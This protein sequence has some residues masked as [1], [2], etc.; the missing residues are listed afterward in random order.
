MKK[1]TGTQR[2]IAVGWVCW[3]LSFGAQ[4]QAVTNKTENVAPE[5]VVSATRSARELNSVPNT[6]YYLNATEEVVH[7]AVRTTPDMLA[8]IPSAFVQ[9]TSYGQGSPYLRG[10]TGFRTLCL[11]DGIRLNNSV[12]RD[13]P[14]QYWNTVDPLSIRAYELVMGPGSV[15]YGSDAVGGTLNALPVQPPDYAGAPTWERRLYYR[16]ATVD[17][18]N[19]GRLQLGGRLDEHLGFVGGVSLKDFGDVRGGKAVGLQEHTGYE[20]LDWDLRADYHFTKDATLTL[21]HQ[22]VRQEDTWRTHRTVY[23]ITWDG[24]KRGDDKSLS[25]DQHRDL[26]YLKF[27]SKDLSGPID[28]LEATVSRQVQSEDIYRIKKDDKGEQQGFD[29]TTWGATLQLQSDTQIGEW[30]YG[31]EY[32]RDSV[33]SYG[34]KYKA[35]GQLDSVEVQGPVADDAAYH[36]LGAFVEDTLKLF[37]GQLDVV[38]GVRYT[39]A[40]VEANRV[41]EP[42]TGKA[43]STEGNWNAAVGSLRLLHP[44]TEDRKHVVFVGVSQGFRA[45]NLSDLTR[46]DIARSTELETPVSDLDPERFV[47]YEIGIKSRAERLTTQ[48]S[49]YYTT[50]EDMIVRAPTG[51]KIDG[52]DEVTKKNSGHG[53]VQ[54]VEL[55][56]TLKLGREWSTWV[57]AAWMEGQVDAYPN[58]TTQEERG[59]LGRLMPPTAEIG[60]RW[61]QESGRYWGELVGD[62][63]A[64]ADKLSAD[65]ARDTQR[66]PPGGTPGYA[67]FHARVGTTVVENLDLT[68]ALENIFDKDYRIHGSGVNEPGRNLVVTAAYSF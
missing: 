63:A 51:R 68:L 56:E 28:G 20:E 11:V 22:T 21:A 65:D 23:G 29:V 38:P 27:Q 17:R 54:G 10:F 57:S 25:Y 52:L 55:T 31:A 24:L 46:L 58:S 26:T 34:R 59:Y 5:I 36:T 14:N 12:F 44:L 18:S 32:Y 47:S 64:K 3:G 16:G 45:P 15:L 19:I 2:V 39:Y 53:F 40:K 41:K 35:N 61:R 60:L 4:A 6:A 42:L 37:G 1:A 62:M 43:T 49:Y 8:G 13:G 48:A 50:I 66:I 9:K 30:V 7:Q 67:V 33:V